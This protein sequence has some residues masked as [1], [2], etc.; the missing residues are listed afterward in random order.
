MGTARR[1]DGDV[2]SATHADESGLELIRIGLRRDEA[3]TWLK[4]IAG[5]MGL[6]WRRAASALAVHVILLLRAGPDYDI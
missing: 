4:L 5:C 3:G 6:A 1:P 2:R